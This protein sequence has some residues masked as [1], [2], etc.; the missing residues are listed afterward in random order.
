MNR[1]A[2]GTLFLL[3][4]VQPTVEPDA[5]AVM[6]GGSAMGSAGGSMGMGGGIAAAGGSAIGGGAG[7][8][9]GGG[10]AGGTA[11]PTG[12]F[13]TSTWDGAKYE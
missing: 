10:A 6:A 3:G 13:D 2:L 9:P 12:S 5:G 1:F 8:P 7:N 4:C 11:L